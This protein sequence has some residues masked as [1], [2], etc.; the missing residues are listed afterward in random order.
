MAG[1]PGKQSRPPPRFSPAR[2]RASN[3]PT[4]AL[5]TGAIGRWPKDLVLDFTEVEC[6]GQ[7]REQMWR[8]G[9]FSGGFGALLE[10]TWRFTIRSGALRSSPASP[11]RTAPI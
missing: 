4:V 6:Y 10:L 11:G 8:R 2:I 9:P 5:A 3:P 7:R 1:C